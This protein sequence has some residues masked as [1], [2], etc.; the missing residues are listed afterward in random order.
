MPRHF[1]RRAVDAAPAALWRVAWRQRSLQAVAAL[2]CAVLGAAALLPPRPLYPL[3]GISVRVPASSSSSSVAQAART[4]TQGLPVDTRPRSTTG[5][6]LQTPG[7]ALPQASLPSTTVP[8]LPQAP[9]AAAMAQAPPQTPLPQATVPPAPQTPLPAFAE[10]PQASGG[11]LPFQE[12]PSQQEQ[13]QIT[14]TNADAESGSVYITFQGPIAQ[15]VVIPPY[16]TV[17]VQ[18]LTGEYAVSLWGD[19]ASLRSGYG[20]FRRRHE[21]Q[22]VWHTVYHSRWDPLGPLRLG[23][24]E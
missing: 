9:V 1:R 16:Q 4:A 6:L 23:D 17:T 21:Y 12:R 8:A 18:L 22:A 15:S 7:G 10:P 3:T 11:G 13:P 2:A 20:V 5:S 14:M 24:S 19:S